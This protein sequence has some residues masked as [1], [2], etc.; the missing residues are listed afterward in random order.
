VD[1]TYDVVDG[2]LQKDLLDPSMRERLADA[3]AYLLEDRDA[4]RGV[5]LRKD[6]SWIPFTNVVPPPRNRALISMGPEDFCTLADL[7]EEDDFYGWLHSHPNWAA[8]PS[9]TDVEF[10]QF[11]GKMLIYSIPEDELNE[12]STAAIELLDRQIH[13]EKEKSNSWQST[14]SALTA[15]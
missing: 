12:F 4:E 1:H 5:M 15:G 3:I 13:E 7:M 2:D 9:F 8:F 14:T 10:H 11:A 6:L